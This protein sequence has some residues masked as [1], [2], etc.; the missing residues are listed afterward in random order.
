MLVGLTKYLCELAASADAQAEEI[1]SNETLE[2]N[3]SRTVT[4]SR[5]SNSIL[6]NGRRDSKENILGKNL[7]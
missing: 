1:L 6:D 2:K 7:R 4:F 3:V 5:G